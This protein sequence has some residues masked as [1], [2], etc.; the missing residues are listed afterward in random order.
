MLDSTVRED[1]KAPYTSAKPLALLFPCSISTFSFGNIL[2][3]CPAACRA[4]STLL[5][6]IRDRVASG[7]DLGEESIDISATKTVVFP[8]PV[9][10]D[11]P[12]RVASFVSSVSR[13]LR[14]QVSWYGRNCTGNE[15]FGSWG[16]A[17]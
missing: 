1:N 8:E 17:V 16:W 15:S 4:N 10:N 3:T 6:I 13:Q 5:T 2:F 11:I 9:G 7:L 14:R 12:I